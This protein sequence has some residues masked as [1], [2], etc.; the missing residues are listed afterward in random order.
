MSIMIEVHPAI[1]PALVVGGGAV[2][3]RKVATLIESGFQV[4]VIAPDIDDGIVEGEATVVIR[5]FAAGDTSGFA[6][7]FAC[8]DNRR[9]N[10][11]VGDEARAAGIPVLVADSQ[12]ESTF[13][14]PAVHR[15]GDLVV[16]ISTGGASPALAQAFRDRVAAL[17][18][19]GSADEV[20]AARAAREARRNGRQE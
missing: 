20:A 19:P 9:V 3:A 8:T 4:T 13:F 12:P 10:R 5:A 17:F 11:E 15:N 7:V 18:G 16:G 14:S 1:G 6:L 2:A